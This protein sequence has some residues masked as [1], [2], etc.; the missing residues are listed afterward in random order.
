M[1]TFFT[2]LIIL[3][4]TQLHAQIEGEK[5]C[6]EVPNAYSENSGVPLFV[7]SNCDVANYTFSLYNRWGELIFEESMNADASELDI[8]LLFKVAGK[9]LKSE[10][11]LWVIAW[12]PA[13][14]PPLST[15]KGKS[16]QVQ[17]TQRGQLTIL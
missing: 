5:N 14:N 16:K 8:A 1:K 11:Y 3:L 15:S 6:F 13:S 17:R 2:V 12:G 10:V 4:S 7:S 9:E